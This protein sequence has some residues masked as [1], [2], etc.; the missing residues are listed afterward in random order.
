MGL[1]WTWFQA[2]DERLSRKSVRT[3]ILFYERTSETEK[4]TI[5][6]VF[7]FSRS[8][9]EN[10]LQ[11]WLYCKSDWA[12]STGKMNIVRWKLLAFTPISNAW[13]TSVQWTSILRPSLPCE[14]SRLQPGHSLW[15]SSGLDVF[16]WSRINQ[17]K[18][19][20]VEIIPLIHF[21]SLL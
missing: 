6:I 14:I 7:S 17:T 16:R 3:P 8:L 2:I 11:I 9:R 19:V 15:R 20:N 5:T 4:G 21:I 1:L 10:V 18:S 13:S 12:S